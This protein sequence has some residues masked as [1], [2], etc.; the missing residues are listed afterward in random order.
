MRRADI[1]PYGAQA[2]STRTWLYLGAVLLGFCLAPLQQPDA[3]PAGAQAAGT[4]TA[5]STPV[6]SPG[7]VRPVT[8]AEAASPG[9]KARRSDDLGL[10]RAAVAD[11]P[12]PRLGSRLHTP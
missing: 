8:E 7:L 5:P 6:E 12:Q 3:P 4:V 1:H 10:L 9:H 2:V 11:A